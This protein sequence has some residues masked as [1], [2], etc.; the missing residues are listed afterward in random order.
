MGIISIS[1]ATVR[2]LLKE[3]NFDF[4]EISNY[5][6]G[7]FE[8]IIRTN[9]DN[10]C[11]AIKFTKSKFARLFVFHSGPNAFNTIFQESLM[12]SLKTGQYDE[13]YVHEGSNIFKL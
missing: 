7:T 8:F 13:I 6:K 4:F 1:V 5:N 12:A 3:Q 11:V 9:K 2:N 10:Q